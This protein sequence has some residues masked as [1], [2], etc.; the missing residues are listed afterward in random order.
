MLKK[1]KFKLR[2][3][4]DIRK[5]LK[6]LERM[7]SVEGNMSSMKDLIER[8]AFINFQNDSLE[9]LKLKYTQAYD[10]KQ[11][12]NTLMKALEGYIDFEQLKN[13]I[14][15]ARELEGFDQDLI[16]RAME[17]LER[18]ERE[19]NLLRDILAAIESGGPTAVLENY[20]GVVRTDHI[21]PL[22]REF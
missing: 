10:Q 12:Q 1:L 8:S 11:T 15:K 5:Q 22:I 17:I 14:A 16:M 19:I 18:F 3:E 9:A 20:A 13:A 2:E 21:E 4:E 6:A 7:K